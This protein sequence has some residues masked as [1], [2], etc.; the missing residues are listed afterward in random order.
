MTTIIVVEILLAM[1]N[2]SFII[3]DYRYRYNLL[4]RVIRIR[5]I[6]EQLMLFYLLVLIVMILHITLVHISYSEF[7]ILNSVI[8]EIRILNSE[9]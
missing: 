9:F 2:I 4:C 7:R 1:D 6:Y 3:I 5:L 8:R